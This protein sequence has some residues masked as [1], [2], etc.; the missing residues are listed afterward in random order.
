MKIINKVPLPQN[1]E[2]VKL[3]DIL[4][5]SY[6]S[7]LTK[8]KR[9]S[10]GK[11]PVYGSSGIVGYHSSSL[12]SG[13]CLIVGR[14]GAVG[15]VHHSPGPCWPIDTTY[16][17]EETPSTN[18][19]FF[20]HLLSAARLGQLDRSTAVPSLS[21]D[22]YDEVFVPV[23]PLNEQRR[24]VEKI[25]ELFS[26][27]DAGVSALERVRANLKRYRAA[28]LKAAIEGRLTQGWRAR[29]PDVEPAAVL[30]QRTVRE[31]RRK[32]EEE[33]LAEFA[34][35]G[36]TPPA[37]WQTRYRE[38]QSPDASNLPKL[39]KGWCWTTI[40]QLTTLVTKGTSPNWQGFDY[41]E[42]GVLF[43]RSQN[44][45]WGT[46]DLSE[47]A[48]LPEAFN[49]THRSSV[50]RSGDV[51]LNLVGASV[52]RT[53]AAT[54]EIN[55]ANLNQAV[56]IIRLVDRAMLNRL[57]V[58]FI[59]SPPVQEYITK[60]K[61]DVARANFNLDDIRPMP[62]PLPPLA[63]QG[64]IVSE[65]ERRLSVVAK[66]EKQVDA[67]LKRAARLRQ[68]ILERAF[69]G[70]LVPQDPNDEPASVLLGRIMSERQTRAASNLA[71]RRVLQST[72]ERRTKSTI[73]SD[74]ES[75]R[76][77]QV[78]TTRRAR[79]T[80]KSARMSRREK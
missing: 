26:E 24:M 38:P 34:E 35:K 22:D 25:E 50:I 45:R 77:R 46:L 7:G 51:L 58:L 29:H 37:N 55:G 32:W 54:E 21:R 17:S 27:L 57:L 72:R 64:E 44:V 36:Q 1:W 41:V 71:P 40:G 2:P 42:Y 65:V 15:A 74:A 53:A 39:P 80:S 52:G 59:L 30:I 69:E 63:E 75:R 33:R 4:P 70:K 60:T 67:G 47:L 12:T 6:G 13:P 73:E 66:V 68:S 31:R 79:R 56:A 76:A 8:E 3:G 62:M 20:Y 48:F 14:K 78:I 43:M 19:R 61:A 9:N 23:P 5:L 18:L 49:S 16:F 11:V 28:I 10:S